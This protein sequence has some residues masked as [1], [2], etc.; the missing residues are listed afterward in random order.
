MGIVPSRLDALLSG[1][2]VGLGEFLW[3]SF[4]P[5]SRISG[6]FILLNEM[7]DEHGFLHVVEIPLAPGYLSD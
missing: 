2:S 5:P 3:I 1:N 6:Q 4:L 7:L